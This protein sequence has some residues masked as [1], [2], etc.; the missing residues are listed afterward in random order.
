MNYTFAQLKQSKTHSSNLLR[1][2]QMVE[3]YLSGDFTLQKLG[4]KNGIT[5]ERCRQIIALVVPKE[6]IK[7]IKLNNL[8]KSYIN[9]TIRITLVCSVC[10]CNF[11]VVP[12][13]KNRKFCSPK[14]RAT[15]FDTPEER[16]LKGIAFTN[17]W[18]DNHREEALIK[19]RAYGKEYYKKNKE[20]VLEY[21][22]EYQANNREAVNKRQ[23]DRCKRLNK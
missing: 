16:R 18:F 1:N 8:K 11:D 12:S 4:D 6:E 13:F 22:K 15:T 20:K 17:R 19:M 9:R 5:R 3:D 21:S 23:R 14:C 2:R 7:K 10:G